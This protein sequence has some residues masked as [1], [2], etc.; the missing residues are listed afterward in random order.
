LV[1]EIRDAGYVPNMKEILHDVGEE[2]KEEL[3][4]Y[5]HKKMTVVFGLTEQES[6]L[7]VCGDCH[8]VM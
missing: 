5:H 1:R 3:L 8:S 4:H 2:Q 7:R 6:L